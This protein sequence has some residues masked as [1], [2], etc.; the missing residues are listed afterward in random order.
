[1]K[2]QEKQ[3]LKEYDQ[4]KHRN[5]GYN[6]YGVWLGA[7]GNIYH[8]ERAQVAILKKIFC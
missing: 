1:M 6:P 7:V 3:W 2:R 5:D 8:K 4:G